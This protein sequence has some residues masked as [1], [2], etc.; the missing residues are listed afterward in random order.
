MHIF[1]VGIFIGLLGCKRL[2]ASERMPQKTPH[3]SPSSSQGSSPQGSRSPSPQRRQLDR[4]SSRDAKYEMH[5]NSQIWSA[6]FDRKG[7]VSTQQQLPRMPGIPGFCRDTFQEKVRKCLLLRGPWVMGTTCVASLPTV[8]NYCTGR[9]EVLGRPLQRFV[10][11]VGLIGLLGTGGLAAYELFNAWIDLRV[12]NA[13][14]EMVESL[15]K[16]E[17]ILQQPGMK[18]QQEAFET[19]KIELETMATQIEVLYQEHKRRLSD[20]SDRLKTQEE[21]IKS[22]DAQ[23]QTIINRCSGH[24]KLTGQLIKQVDEHQEKL[25]LLEGSSEGLQSDYQKVVENQKKL[26]AEMQNF[27]A[28]SFSLMAELQQGVQSL[29]PHLGA[30]TRTLGDSAHIFTPQAKKKKLEKK[31]VDPLNLM[32]TS[33]LS[34][35]RKVMLPLNAHEQDID[36]DGERSAEQPTSKNKNQNGDDG[37]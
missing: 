7:Q 24:Q 2:D 4:Q 26:N 27:L 21:E 29:S 12:C 16:I 5:Q 33:P 8:L 19:M 20:H 14:I 36:Q 9:S 18:N 37:W 1:F 32:G 25:K 6:F 23:L 15:H 3:V 30:Q 10:A 28:E 35:P 11:G 34:L 13:S 31:T 22:N 17:H